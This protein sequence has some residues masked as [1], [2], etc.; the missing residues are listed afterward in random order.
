MAIFVLMLQTTNFKAVNIL[1]MSSFLPKVELNMKHL[2]IS[3]SLNLFVKNIDVQTY[4]QLLCIKANK[5]SKILFGWTITSI[6]YIMLV[7]KEIE[8][9]IIH[10][11]IKELIFVLLQ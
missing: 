5:S 10:E 3:I 1:K 6:N 4:N 11:K 8:K 9:K 7:R 2:L